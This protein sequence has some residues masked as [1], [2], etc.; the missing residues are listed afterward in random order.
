MEQSGSPNF[1]SCVNIEGHRVLSLEPLTR[2]QQLQGK[3]GCSRQ[4]SQYDP[5]FWVWENTHFQV[6]RSVASIGAGCPDRGFSQRP[7][8]EVFSLNFCLVRDLILDVRLNEWLNTGADYSDSFCRAI[9]QTIITGRWKRAD[10][11]PAAAKVVRGY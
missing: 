9:S 11:L 6:H 3:E 8:P 1:I 5:G 2:Q 4:G 10:A 7:P